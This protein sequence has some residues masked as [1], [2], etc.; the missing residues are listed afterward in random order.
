MKKQL[1]CLSLLFT[2]LISCKDDNEKII[3][4]GEYD[5]SFVHQ[6]FSPPMK[7]DTILNN[8]SHFYIGI[9]S[10]DINLDGITD[11]Y[12]KIKFPSQ[13]SPENYFYNPDY[14]YCKL[15]YTSEVEILRRW[16]AYGCGLGSCSE[17]SN[18]DALRFGDVFGSASDWSIQLTEIPLWVDLDNDMSEYGAWYFLENDIRYIGIRL[19]DKENSSA[20]YKY[21]WIKINFK[22]REN[23]LIESCAIEI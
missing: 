11:I 8:M 6:G 2:M 17:Y 18:V 20:K 12:F 22:S 16:A 1:F 10:I 15:I 19:K 21:G 9:D 23:M 14:S 13:N 5:S 4:A 3:L 7:L